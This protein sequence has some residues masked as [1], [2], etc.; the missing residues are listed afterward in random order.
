MPLSKKPLVV[1]IVKYSIILVAVLS[2]VFIVFYWISV[3]NE[4]TE[5]VQ[6]MLCRISGGTG[7]VLA[8]S[9]AYGIIV[10][11]WMCFRRRC[12]FWLWGVFGYTV[13][14]IAGMATTVLTNIILVIIKGNI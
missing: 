1:R 5:R 8:I 3:A 10:D 9:S 7:L 11:L 2:M 12:A 13:L 6:L 14:L 4:W